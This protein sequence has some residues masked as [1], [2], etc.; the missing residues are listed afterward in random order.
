MRHKLH[1]SLELGGNAFLTYILQNVP[2][3][4]VSSGG[5]CS[6]GDGGISESCNP[7]KAIVPS[8]TVTYCSLLGESAGRV[9]SNMSL[10]TRDGQESE[11]L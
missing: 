11:I 5:G 7:K 1:T 10:Y 6:S 3:S 2:A 8:S 9:T 4:I